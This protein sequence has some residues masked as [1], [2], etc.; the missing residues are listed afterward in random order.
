MQSLVVVS[1]PLMHI[2]IHHNMID[3]YVHLFSLQKEYFCGVAR[4]GYQPQDTSDIR[5][6][7][8][9]GK[10]CDWCAALWLSA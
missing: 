2:E 1:Y 8:G 7:D 5:R 10:P 4:Q 9:G 3:F 6:E